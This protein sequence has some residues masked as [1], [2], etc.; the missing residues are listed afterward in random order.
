M[1]TKEVGWSD[2]VFMHVASAVA[3]PRETGSHRTG[4]QGHGLSVTSGGD[5]AQSGRSRCGGARPELA[6]RRGGGDFG[7][8]PPMRSAA[9]GRGVRGRRF[10]GAQQR[11]DRRRQVEAALA[12]GAHDAGEHLLGVCTVARAVP[13]HTL[14]MTTAGRMA[15]S[16]RQLVA[17]SEGSHKKRNT[18]GNSVARC[19]AKRS[20][21]ASGSGASI[22]LPRR[23]LSRP[24][25]VARPCSLGSPAL[26]PCRRSTPACRTAY[27]PPAQELSGSSR[28]CLQR[29]SK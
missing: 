20:A 27:T 2:S 15:C 18:A 11:G 22:S 16:A 17:S 12:G 13:P 9:E 6:T 8:R 14:R 5:R 25:A 28:R 10:R 4:A 19:A 29:W 1:A 7:R 23:A 3:I 24:G 21:S 26:Q